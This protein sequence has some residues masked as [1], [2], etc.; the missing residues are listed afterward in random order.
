[1]AFADELVSRDATARVIL[2]DARERPGGHWN[3]AYPFVSL[4]QPAAW[5]GVNSLPLGKGGGDLSSGAEILAYYARVLA[6]L[7][8]TGRVRFYGGCVYEGEGRFENAADGGAYRVA[9][10]AKIVDATYARVSV[11]STTPPAFEVAAE[12]SLVAPNDLVDVRDPSA[13]VVVIGGGKTGIDAV[14]FLLGQGVEPAGITWIVPNDAWLLDRALIQ[15]GRLTD[16]GADAQLASAANAESLEQ[17]FTTLERDERILRLDAAVWPTKYRCAT[18][19]RAELAQLRRVRGVV[20]QGRVQEITASEIV[21]ERGTLET[22]ASVLHVNCT[23]DGLTR[24]EPRPVFASGQI[25]LQPLFLCHPTFSAALIAYVEARCRTDRERNELCRVVPY[26][27]TPS[28]YLS[29]YAD[30]LDNWI[31]WSRRMPWWL[32]TSRLS[33]AHHE[34]LGQLI[35]SSF[36]NRKVMPSAIE[37]LRRLGADDPAEV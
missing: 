28:D 12:V 2:V 24:T 10:H 1:M 35:W 3:D 16:G 18:V 15:P 17:L 19:S 5:Y 11:P 29:A 21:L 8:R 33:L 27:V 32:R 9:E 22:N 30:S 14:L 23:A 25:T 36:K 20:R 31:G 7:T 4:H 6:K 34:P 13:G 26:P 37:R